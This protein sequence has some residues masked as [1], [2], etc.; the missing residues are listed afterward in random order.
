MN[1]RTQILEY[2]KN[3]IFLLN[4][5]PEFMNTTLKLAGKMQSESCIHQP[6]V[7]NG[8][9]ITGRNESYCKCKGFWTGIFCHLTVCDKRPC[10]DHGV[11]KL[12]KDSGSGFVCKCNSGMKQHQDNL[13]IF[14]L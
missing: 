4:K 9:C 11:C 12:N 6:C 5:D 7:N 3:W 13:L 14:N 8:S 1:I 2:I 10:G